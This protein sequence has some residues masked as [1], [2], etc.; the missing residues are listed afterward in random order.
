VVVAK[1]QADRIL[2]QAAPFHDKVAFI[3]D[4]KPDLGYVAALLA[5]CERCNHWANRGPLYWALAESYEKHMN[6][7]SSLSIV[8][9]ANGGIA[10]E[11]LA[12]FHDVMVGK[13]QRWVGSAFSF[14]NL[15]RG[16]FASMSILDCDDR[17]MLDLSK[18]QAMDPSEY[19]GFVVT[20]IFGLWPDFAPYIA[21]ARQSGKHMLID[22]AAGIDER[23]PDWPY[24]TFSLHHTKPYGVGEGGLILAPHD[25]ADAVYE[26]LDYGKIGEESHHQWLNNGKLSD[27]ACAFH[28]D[29][30][31]RYQQWT[32]RYREQAARVREIAAEVGLRPLILTPRDV[33]ATSEPYIANGPISAEKIRKTQ[34]ITLGKY[35]KPLSNRPTAMRIFSSII[36]IPTHPDIERISDNDLIEGLSQLVSEKPKLSHA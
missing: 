34:R 13:P 25:E 24:Q 20:N 16:W 28:L 8:P 19:D 35:Y 5:Q 14:G 15:G 21:F 17:G 6:L 4:K 22:N 32:P 2:E 7:P 12:R 27:I 26:L 11:T 30:L 23:V 3:E 33:P 1:Q 10:L 9:C 29:R 36:N 18:L 31:A